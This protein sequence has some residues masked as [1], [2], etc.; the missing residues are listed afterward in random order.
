L[1]VA[2]LSFVARLGD[3]I[4]SVDPLKVLKAAM[5]LLA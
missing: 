3:A 5:R 2:R 1:K 4:I